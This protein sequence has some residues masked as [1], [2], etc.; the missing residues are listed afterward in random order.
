ME[1]R[2]RAVCGTLCLCLAVAVLSAVALVYLTVII[3]IPTQREMS[4]GINEIPVMCTT[5]ERKVIKDDI[6]ACRWSSCS[7]WCLSKGGGACTHLYVSVRNN[8]SNVEFEECTDIVHTKCPS[9]DRFNL[10]KKNCKKDHQ[11][12]QLDKTFRCEF[13]K[14]WNITDVYS[15]TWQTKDPELNCEKKRNCVDLEGMY[16]CHQGRCG[17]IHDWK[18][19]RRCA[20]IQSPGKNVIIMSGEEIVLGNCRRAIST[21]SGETVWNANDNEGTTLLT[22]C[23]IL[24]KTGTD[25]F[26]AQ[27]C[28]NG[29]LLPQHILGREPTNLTT[30]QNVF[31]TKSLQYKMD[32]TAVRFPYE[33]DI[34]IF[35][36]SRLMINV[37]GCVNTLQEE[38][39]NFYE[40]H[41]N[42]GRNHSAPS[43][44]PCFYSPNNPE[45]VVARYN[46]NQSRWIFLMFFII[47]A[48]LFILSCGVLF[49]C[50]RCL[51]VDNS[52]HMEMNCCHTDNKEL[53][54]SSQF[55]LDKDAD[56]L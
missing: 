17:Q 34:T 6:V 4:A 45:F 48:S 47:P 38:C 1:K 27:D 41:G 50:S 5:T 28:I 10:Q 31:H 11:C 46:L 23:T 19:E 22:S 3:Y 35:N 39:S 40:T 37:E 56:A 24:G 26:Q 44:Y 30:L 14:C 8:G 49:T 7:E 12:T 13:G 21:E 55:K 9:L 33:G 43:R 32:P 51:N 52:G 53:S 20:D 42:D 18:C 2:E 25:Y 15:C 36:Q 16:D 29:T 54:S